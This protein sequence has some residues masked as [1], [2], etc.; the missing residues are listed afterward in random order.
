M[1]LKPCPFCG[2]EVG[3]KNNARSDIGTAYWVRC[4][5]C[6]AV[7]PLTI[8]GLD[9]AAELWNERVV[10]PEVYEVVSVLRGILNE[11]DSYEQRHGKKVTWAD[12]ARAAIKK[13]AP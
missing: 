10:D 1:K 3:Y 4:P 13:I 9:Q 2:S 8:H 5:I 12:E 6:R 11:A 7:G